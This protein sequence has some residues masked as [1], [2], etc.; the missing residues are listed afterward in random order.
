[1]TYRYS[2]ICVYHDIDRRDYI[3]CGAGI[4]PSIESFVNYEWLE[5]SFT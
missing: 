5:Y 2:G 1:M 4:S 3:M